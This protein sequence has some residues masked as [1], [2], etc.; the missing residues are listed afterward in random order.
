MQEF[1][2][3]VSYTMAENVLRSLSNL[4]KY[5]PA[6]RHKHAHNCIAQCTVESK[7]KNN[8]QSLRN[9]PWLQQAI[10]TSHTE[11]VQYNMQCIASQQ[12]CSYFSIDDHWF[13]KRCRISEFQ[14]YQDQ[15][16]I[17]I[18]RSTF[19]SHSSRNLCLA[20][21]YQILMMSCSKRVDKNRARC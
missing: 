9:V 8:G 4:K 7:Q 19:I 10:I 5:M 21:S 2:V 20:S 16:I 11:C 17:R 6:S 12:H 3:Q 1:K 15:G 13:A 14:I 18:S